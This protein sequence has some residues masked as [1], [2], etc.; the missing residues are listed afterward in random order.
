[1]YY[2]YKINGISYWKKNSNNYHMV[3]FEDNYIAVW[4][5]RGTAAEPEQ[6]DEQVQF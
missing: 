6:S 1:M 3:F 4:C 5:S 2:Y